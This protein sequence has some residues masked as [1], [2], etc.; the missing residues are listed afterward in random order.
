MNPPAEATIGAGDDIL[1]PGDSGEIENAVG[2]NLGMLDDVGGVADNAWDQDLAVGQLGVP[3]DL[4]LVLVADIAGLDRE[5]PGPDLQ[6]HIDDVLEGQVGG[7]RPVPAAPADVIAD[8][9]FG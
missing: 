7:M 6:Q 4:P 8:L 2:D 1:A 5:R 9:L 3:P